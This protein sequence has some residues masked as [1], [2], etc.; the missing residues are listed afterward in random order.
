VKTLGSHCEPSGAADENIPAAGAL[1]MVGFAQETV[2]HAIRNSAVP[3][4]KLG[5]QF[6]VSARISSFFGA[7]SRGSHK[8]V[9]RRRG[10]TKMKEFA[11]TAKRRLSCLKAGHMKRSIT[12]VFV[13]LVIIA[14]AGIAIALAPVVKTDMASLV[15]TRTV[16]DS[17]VIPAPEPTF[18][19]VI[20]KNVAQSTAWWAPQIAPSKHAPNV[21]LVLYDDEGFGASSTFGGMIPMPYQ[22]AFAKEGL[23]YNN[24]H[25][26]SLCSPTRAAL[27]TGR[28]HGEDGYEMIAELAT[29]FPGYKGTIG[30]ENASVGRPFALLR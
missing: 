12:V 7:Q 2:A 24:F 26:T 6:I 29:G 10:R 5:N 14:S 3:W 13:A 11:S 1:A 28:N 18:G 16:A 15:A 9:A 23:R 25:T 4:K 19:G 30:K 20:D 21:V 8:P 22:D 17:N 27:I